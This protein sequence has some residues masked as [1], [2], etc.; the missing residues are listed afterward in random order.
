LFFLKLFTFVPEDG[1]TDR[2]V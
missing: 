1:R 2:N